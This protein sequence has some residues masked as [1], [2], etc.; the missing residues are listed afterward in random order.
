MM[1]DADDTHRSRSLA[2]LAEHAGRRERV[3][4]DHMFTFGRSGF[5]LA[6][7]RLQ[8]FTAPGLRP[9]AVVTQ[10][11]RE[12]AVLMNRAERYAE[13]VWT[14]HCPN[15]PEPPIWIAHQFLTLEDD[16]Q[17]MGFAHV[18]F[19]VTGS[20]TIAG[21]PLW[22]PRLT[23]D[24]LT[25]LVGGPVDPGRG[26]GYVARPAE[27]EPQ[28][29]YKAAL[30]V[31]LPRPDLDDDSRACMRAGLGWLG[32]LA[33]QVSPA[34]RDLGCCWYHQGDWHAVNRAAI[35]L[36]RRAREAGVAADDIAVDVVGQVEEYGLT[37]WEREAFESLFREP[38]QP[39]REIGYINGRHRAKAML[40]LGVRR[41]LVCRWEFPGGG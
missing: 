38:I 1:R 13:A 6:T 3:V 29:R 8:L 4:D 2:L 28:M 30:V 31:T 34:R 5:E 21:P 27:P 7:F 14:A 19:K 36:V 33:G 41:V 32:R 11:S 20:H 18:G 23:P 24:E 25:E 35:R 10:T 17:D 22:G 37:G 9:V 40:D 12:G 26:S 15:E 39:E 16:D